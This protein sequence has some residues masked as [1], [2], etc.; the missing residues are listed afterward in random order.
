MTY[1]Y[2][3]YGYSYFNIR[4]PQ[5]YD[6][7][8]FFR[9]QDINPTF[10]KHTIMRQKRTGSRRM[11]AAST[12]FRLTEGTLSHV[13]LLDSVPSLLWRHNGR[14]G[15]L[16][17][18]P[19]ESLLNRPCRR[20]SK[21]TSKLCV[22]GLCARNSPVTG[23]IPAQRASNAENASIWWRHH[24]IGHFQINRYLHF[25][26][27]TDLCTCNKKNPDASVFVFVLLARV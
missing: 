2:S 16:N 10:C 24:V 14:N 22:T 21:K 4:Y 6:L 5:S 19:D 7:L 8:D 23:E 15:V 27:F 20:R 17:H 1:Y 12:K 11:L 3:S 26:R 9:R 13:Y 18:Q 25:C